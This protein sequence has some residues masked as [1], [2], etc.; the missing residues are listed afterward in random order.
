VR[1][2]YGDQW[3]QSVDLARLLAVAVAFNVP[4]SLCATALLSSGAVTTIA[5]ATILSALQSVVLV[6]A[7]ASQ[8][9]MA[10]GLAMIVSAAITTA[11]WLRATSRHIN[12]PLRGMWSHLRKSATVALMAAIGPAFALWLYGPYPDVV[13]MPLVFGV[14]GGLTGFVLGVII[15]KHPLLEEMVQMWS[16]I[17]RQAV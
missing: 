6:A 14:A 12:L 4:A 5:R 8:G 10:L 16:K 11:I 2:L 17:R 3:G 7:G 1:V 13:V 9:L 15:S